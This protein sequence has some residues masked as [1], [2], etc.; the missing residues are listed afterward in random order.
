MLYKLT[1]NH[2]S[3]K[4]I[5]FSK[6]LNIILAERTQLSGEKDSRNTLGKT[7]FIEIVDFCLGSDFTKQSKLYAPELEDWAFT[8]DLD[9]YGY[10]IEAT[11]HI[12]DNKKIYIHPFSSTFPIKLKQS[13][14]KALKYFIFNHADLIKN[15]IIYVK[16]NFK[17]EKLAEKLDNLYNL[18]DFNKAKA[19]NGALLL[20][21]GFKPSPL[22]SEIINETAFL[23]AINELNQDNIEEYIKERWC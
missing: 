22:F 16:I 7:T 4:S 12:N 5:D 17:D 9:I 14:D 10:R 8:L 11:R 19:V 15:I 1:A 21:L 3:F 2:S 13:D 23:L 6:G 20:F 18:I